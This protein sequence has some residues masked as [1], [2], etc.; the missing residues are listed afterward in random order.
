MAD[1]KEHRLK[2]Q[3]KERLKL[4]K[5]RRER[6]KFGLLT[7]GFAVAIGSL[8]YLVSRSKETPLPVQSP[9]EKIGQTDTPIVAEQPRQPNLQGNKSVVFAPKNNE[10]LAMDS[11]LS[12]NSVVIQKPTPVKTVELPPQYLR[13]LRPP[14]DTEYLYNIFLVIIPT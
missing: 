10:T 7:I 1:L 9:I 3:F 8:I 13:T 2:E 5:E 4:Q 12:N 14:V 11:L 6:T